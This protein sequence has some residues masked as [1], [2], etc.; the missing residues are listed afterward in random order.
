[1]GLG[2]FILVIVLLGLAGFAF[3]VWALVDALQ[4]PDDEWQHAGQNKL[5]WILVMIFLGIL[6]SFIYL[7]VARPSLEE[8]RDQPW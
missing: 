5:V 7:V 3:W 2:F 6:G 8:T 4:R 1:M